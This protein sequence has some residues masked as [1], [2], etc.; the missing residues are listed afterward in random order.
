MPTGVSG[1][2]MIVGDDDETYVVKFNT[3]PDHTALNEL[4]CACIAEQFGL[5]SF[6]PVLVCIDS[7]QAAKI[8]KGRAGPNTKP[9]AAGIHFAVRL[10]TQMY[11]AGSLE[12]TIGHKIARDDLSNAG[13]IPDVLGFDTLVQNCDRHCGN[14]CFVFDADTNSYSFRIFDHSHAFGGPSW[15]PS[16]IGALYQDLIPISEF[17][18]PTDGIDTSCDFDEFLYLAKSSLSYTLG[19]LAGKEG[20]PTEWSTEDGGIVDIKHAIESLDL[21]SLKV[22]IVSHLQGGG[23]V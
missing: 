15:S 11:G 22:A 7:R 18:L 10:V 3:P 2:W 14:V 17:C 23:G 4:V 1:A 8:N 21:E 16:S 20:V 13:C 19:A 6:E 9:I 5:P 12:A